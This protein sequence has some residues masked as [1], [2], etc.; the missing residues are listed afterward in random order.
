MEWTGAIFLLGVVLIIMALFSWGRAR[1]KQAGTNV[2]AREHLERAKQKQHVR[3]DMQELMVEIEQMAKRLGA[4]LDAKT[5]HIEK[6]IREADERIA[7]LEALRASAPGA[8]QSVSAPTQT[9]TPPARSDDA[10]AAETADASSAEDAGELPPPA[11]EPYTDPLMGRVYALADAGKGP[12]AI[13]QE[14]QEQVGK[15]ELIL[16]LRSA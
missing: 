2:T 3:N 9:P 16:A 7:Q 6:A 8:V 5:I 15:V 1:R 10:D 4:H 12:Q 11:D 13:A 14:L